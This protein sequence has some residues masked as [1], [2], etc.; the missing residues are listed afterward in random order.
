MVPPPGRALRN[1]CAPDEPTRQP[2]DGGELIRPAGCPQ[3]PL[4]VAID[5][6]T[7]TW[8]GGPAG[9]GSQNPGRFPATAFL[10]GA[11]VGG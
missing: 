6:G 4:L 9:T 8:P 10:W 7:H 3:T 2:I 1:G 5:D 11:F